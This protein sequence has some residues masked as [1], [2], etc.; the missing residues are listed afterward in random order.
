ML[1]PVDTKRG[2][3]DAKQHFQIVKGMAGSRVE[4]THECLSDGSLER[5]IM[6]ERGRPPLCDARP[7][8]IDPPRSVRIF[9]SGRSRPTRL[10][11]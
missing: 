1:A 11:G 5:R 10:I 6:A 4:A 3:M 8:Q 2:G 7:A 9:E